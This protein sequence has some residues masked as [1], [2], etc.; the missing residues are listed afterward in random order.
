[1]QNHSREMHR[2]CRIAFYTMYIGGGKKGSPEGLEMLF[3][4]V[5]CR[6]G[7]WVCV[8]LLSLFSPLVHARVTVK[9]PDQSCTG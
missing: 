8:C 7:P 1:M 4:L 2:N 5:V 9:K 6:Y 3:H